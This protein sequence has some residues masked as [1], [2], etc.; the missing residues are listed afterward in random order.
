MGVS[1]AIVQEIL[2]CYRSL[3][4]VS[5]LEYLIRHQL[6]STQ[7]K[8]AV[9][10]QEMVLATKA[11]VIFTLNPVTGKDKEL[12][13]EVVS[14]LGEA[15]VSGQTSGE[16]YRFDWYQQKIIQAPQGAR[17][18]SERA[19]IKMA[20]TTAKLQ[21]Y[22]GYP[23][24]LEF[25]YERGQL[26]IVQARPITKIYYRDIP[27]QWTTAD[28]KDGGV[29]ATVCTPM[30]WSFYHY[31][32][33]IKFREFLHHC[34]LVPQREL[35]GKLGE[36]FYGRGYW[37]LSKTKI[38]MA[39]VPG[40]KEKD[41][42][43]SLGIKITYDGD[44]VTTSLNPKTLVQ[45]LRILW[46]NHCQTRQALRHNQELQKALL[47]KFQSYLRD[48]KRELTEQ[49]LIAK[50]RQLTHDD[51]LLTEGSYFQ[52]IYINTVGQA[53]Y[54]DK[55][56]R[57]LSASEYLGLLSGLKDVSH[58][59][60]FYSLVALSRKIRTD[61]KAWRFWSKSSAA[62]LT[63][64]FK[65]QP[66]NNFWPEVLAHLAEF[67]YHS[68]KELDVTY[69]CYDEDY[70]SVLL[71]LQATVKLT[72]GDLNG[73]HHR[74]QKKYQATLKLL[75]ARA[76]ARKYR[77]LYQQIQTMR[78]MLWWREE[79]R[80]IS[81]R[82]YYLLRHYTLKIATLLHQ[83]KVLL[84]KEEIWLLTVDDLWAYFAGRLDRLALQKIIAQNSLYYDSYRNFLSDNEIGQV[85]DRAPAAVAAPSKVS[86]VLTGIACSLGIVTGRARVIHDFS[87]VNRLQAGDIL[88]TRFTDTGWTSKFA[89][90]AAV[91]TESGG[92]LCHAAVVSREYGLPCVAG[93]VAATKIIKDGAWVQVDGARGQVTLIKKK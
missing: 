72:E 39:M 31:I 51:Y 90:L 64:A 9:L 13:I 2:A 77:S 45:A 62:T 29:S 15:L 78:Q 23:L 40:Y 91:V 69:P 22:F 75:R 53:M 70:L 55:L 88:V 84:R 65:K 20:Q 18:L 16:Q 57:Y 17:L 8:M 12:V 33:E 28:F 44:G 21:Q 43:N 49:T 6:P 41:F 3:Y 79:L 38:G 46:I 66:Q 48:L 27:D 50:W 30:M 86:S 76:G 58:L 87:E 61:Q 10:I 92:V 68:D 32:W 47:A 25:A 34:L 54:K 4:S 89:L 26:F 71:Q 67:G 59:R 52:L 73:E 83:K 42:D 7:L 85:F 37:N 5:A 19:L 93:V 74:A 63:A 36:M 60:P 24:D 80:D 81:T 56:S 1:Q 14:G 35:Q 11:G 82:F